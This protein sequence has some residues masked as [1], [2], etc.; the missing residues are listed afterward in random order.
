M[1]DRYIS[2]YPLPEGEVRELLVVIMEEF[3]EVSVASAKAMRFGLGDGY[4][5]S[6]TTNAMDLS[7]EV[8]DLMAVFDMLL[9]RGVG[10]P[11][12]EYVKD[13]KRR[14]LARFMQSPP[15]PTE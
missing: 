5:G 12:T 4:P 15:P 10:W 11:V 7:R 14:K 3:A 13:Q 1:E 2:P 9:E 6:G 8:A